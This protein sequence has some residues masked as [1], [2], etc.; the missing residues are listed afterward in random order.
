MGATRARRGG[1]RPRSDV[2][3]AGEGAVVLLADR[4]ADPEVYVRG[5]VSHPD[6]ATIMLEGWHRVMINR[7]RPAGHSS[8]ITFL[9]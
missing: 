7:E 1:A 6:H 9:D 3:G 8:R 5:H 2:E 4:V